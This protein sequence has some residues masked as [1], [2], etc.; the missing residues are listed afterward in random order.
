MR[1]RD[2]QYV[3]AR[4]E[5]CWDDLHLVDSDATQRWAFFIC[6]SF[7]AYLPERHDR[8]RRPLPSAVSQMIRKTSRRCTGVFSLHSLLFSLRKLC[9]P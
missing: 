5:R 6:F 9:I 2:T 1:H 7:F 3:L 8:R 4:V